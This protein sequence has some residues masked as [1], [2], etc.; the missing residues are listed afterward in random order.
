MRISPGCVV[1]FIVAALR[2]A[3]YS[4]GK[5]LKRGRRRHDEIDQNLADVDGV[6]RG[7]RRFAGTG[8]A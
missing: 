7:G 1:L 3:V 6:L 4:D 2:D 8:R 5:R